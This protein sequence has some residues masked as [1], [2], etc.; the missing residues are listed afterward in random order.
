MFTLTIK[1]RDYIPFTLR[2]SAQDL[3]T[4]TMVM[5]SGLQMRQQMEVE[6]SGPYRSAKIAQLL[7]AAKLLDAVTDLIEFTTPRKEDVA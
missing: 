4:A 6:V 7:N 1:T 2:G 5:Q 3:L